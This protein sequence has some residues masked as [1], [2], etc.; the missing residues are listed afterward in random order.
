[1]PI[2]GA[3]AGV[4]AGDTHCEGICTSKTSKHSPH[5]TEVKACLRT[6]CNSALHEGH[7]NWYVHSVMRSLR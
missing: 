5:W 2:F 4:E 7:E 3:E 6:A 1:M